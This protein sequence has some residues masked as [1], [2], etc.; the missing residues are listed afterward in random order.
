MN[1]LIH[2]PNVYGSDLKRVARAAKINFSHASAID[3][4]CNAYKVTFYN[5]G[6]DAVEQHIWVADSLDELMRVLE[7]FFVPIDG[8]IRGVE[9]LGHCTIPI[10]L[11]RD[12]SEDARFPLDTQ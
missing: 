7:S 8:W 3:E 1:P 9:W 12:P 6:R 4:E 10:A 2:K 11:W 5:A